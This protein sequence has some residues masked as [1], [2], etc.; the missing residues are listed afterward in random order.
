[1]SPTNTS[2]LC[3][4][5]PALSAFESTEYVI[6]WSSERNF[7]F[8]EIN[9]ILNSPSIAHC[10]RN[11]GI[12][13]FVNRPQ[14]CGRE[15]LPN[16]GKYVLL[17][18]TLGPKILKYLPISL[19]KPLKSLRKCNYFKRKAFH[20]SKIS[21]KSILG[22]LQLATSDGEP[23]A[24]VHFIV[25]QEVVQWS[26]PCWSLLYL[27]ICCRLLSL[28]RLDKYGKTETDLLESFGMG[29]EKETERTIDGEMSFSG[30]GN[31]I[32]SWNVTVILL[33]IKDKTWLRKRTKKNEDICPSVPFKHLSYNLTP[34]DIKIEKKEWKETSDPSI[35]VNY[36]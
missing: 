34:F 13:L 17:H 1:M 32:K 12:Q 36:C 3:R 22:T 35:R 5:V 10:A 19:R 15:L 7:T 9:W 14:F 18:A 31:H 4:R 26:F 20:S 29:L 6:P 27:N 24:Q 2:L 16:V 33:E 21:W 11:K 8:K 30:T 23:M 28:R 25:V